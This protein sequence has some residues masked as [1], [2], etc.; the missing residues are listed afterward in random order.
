M[1]PPR[2]HGFWVML[3]LALFVGVGMAPRWQSVMCAALLGALSV[4]LAMWVERRAPDR[5]PLSQNPSPLHPGALRNMSSWCH[6][7][8]SHPRENIL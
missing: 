7:R 8:L 3:T 5:Q 1:K 2:E 6:P 4:G